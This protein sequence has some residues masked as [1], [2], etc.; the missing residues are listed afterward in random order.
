MDD[1]LDIKTSTLYKTSKK[2]N[3]GVK[4]LLRNQM[5]FGTTMLEQ[6]DEKANM[7][8]SLSISFL[9]GIIVV[10]LEFE[11]YVHFPYWVLLILAFGFLSTALFILL[12]VKPNFRFVSKLVEKEISPTYP[13][14]ED[15]SLIFSDYLSLADMESGTDKVT[16]DG[17][18]QIGNIVR[19]NYVLKG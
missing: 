8:L 10:Y 4:E 1:N 12:T 16:S 15:R 2:E 5:I 14:V 17:S 11:S 19:A 18:L 6:S 7:L 13:N 3:K 9:I